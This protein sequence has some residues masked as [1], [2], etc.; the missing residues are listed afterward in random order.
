M[1]PIDVPMTR[2]MLDVQP[3]DEEPALQLD[4]VVVV[5]V[6]E[7]LPQPVARLRR[8]PVPDVVG[9]DDEVRRRVEQAAVFE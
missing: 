8:L 4:H 3:V 1:P 6:R 5:V 9:D 2:E 7:A